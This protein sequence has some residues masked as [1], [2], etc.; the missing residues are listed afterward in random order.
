[1]VCIGVSMTL[2]GVGDRLMKVGICHNQAENSL[3][4]CYVTESKIMLGRCADEAALRRSERE[5]LAWPQIQ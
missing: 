5:A 4:Q 2:G 3:G 1:M